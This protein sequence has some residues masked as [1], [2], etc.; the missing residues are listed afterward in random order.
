MT[1][2]SIR[3]ESVHI[4]LEKKQKQKKKNIEKPKP[5]KTEK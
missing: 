5:S 1:T 4:I 2:C 3:N